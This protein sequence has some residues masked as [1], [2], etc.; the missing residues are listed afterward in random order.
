MSKKKQRKINN[1]TLEENLGKKHVHLILKNERIEKFQA[2]KKN[3]N[4]SQD[5]DVL[6]TCLDIVYNSIDSEVLKLRPELSNIVNAFLNN[7]YLKK[8]HF[9]FNSNDV[10]NEAVHYWIQS[11]RSELNLHSF[12]FR[13]ELSEDEQLVAL[14]F[15]EHQIDFDTGMSLE[16]IK[17]LLPDLDQLKINQIINQF[18]N[19]SLILASN[20][21]NVS[22]Y[23]APIS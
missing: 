4:L 20:I 16:D 15:V 13:K 2:I 6:R 17:K 22:Y 5:V 21:N 18:L 11:R 8:K 9:V 7:T 12:A 10:I 23:Y 3:Y 14:V 1:I 19:N